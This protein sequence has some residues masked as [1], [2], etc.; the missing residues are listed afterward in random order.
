MYY[1][2]A[3]SLPGS[4]LSIIDEKEL[5]FEALPI[6]KLSFEK[7]YETMVFTVNDRDPITF[8]K[9]QPFEYDQNGLTQF[10]KS[11]YNEDLDVTYQ[12]RSDQGSLKLLIEG[13]ILV[14]LDP[15]SKDMFRE[16]HFGY[17]KFHRDNN[18]EIHSFSRTDNTFSNLV[19]QV[20][21]ESGS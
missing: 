9:Y 1:K 19:F 16:E 17:I 13:E 10:E 8:E 4:P 18:G 20:S 15:F 5:A 12:V 3:P 11:F 14:S 6:I 7:D 21:G 2:R